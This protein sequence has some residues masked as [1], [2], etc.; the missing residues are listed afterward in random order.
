MTALPGRIDATRRR[1]AELRAG[2]TMRRDARAQQFARAVQAVRDNDD[3]DTA[4]VRARF[5]CSRQWAQRV[6][7]SARGKS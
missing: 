7:A 4:A 2:S 6:V 5:G 1:H 3:M